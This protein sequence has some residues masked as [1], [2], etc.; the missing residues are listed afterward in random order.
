MSAV[1]N[2]NASVIRVN[3]DVHHHGNADDLENDGAHRH[4]IG[5]VEIHEIVGMVR[6]LTT[7]VLDIFLFVFK[8]IFA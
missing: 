4:Q 6:N 8:F 2:E 1:L 7:S 3:A 5:V